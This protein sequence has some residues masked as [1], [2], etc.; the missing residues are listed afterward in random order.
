MQELSRIIRS[1]NAQNSRTINN[2]TPQSIARKI[3]NILHAVR[4]TG[5]KAAHGESISPQDAQKALLDIFSLANLIT[6]KSH[7]IDYAKPNSHINLFD[8]L[9]LNDRHSFTDEQVEFFKKF[10]KFLVDKNQH[11]FILDGYAGTGKTYLISVL[12]EYLNFIE[13]ANVI[14]SPTG[15][16]AQV[17][18]A[19]LA[20]DEAQTIHSVVYQRDKLVE[21]KELNAENSQDKQENIE[22]KFHFSLKENNFPS[23]CVYIFDEASMIS[24]KFSD[25]ES[26]I[27]GS[28]RL[29]KDAFDFIDIG[30]KEHSKKVLFIGDGAQLPPVKMSTSPALDK[31]YLEKN[32]KFNVLKSK[33]TQVV[34][35]DEK[36]GILKASLKLRRGLE[37]GDF[38]SLQFE[39]D[40][41]IRK[42]SYN[43]V[44]EKYA[45]AVQKDGLNQTKMIAYTNDGVGRLNRDIRATLGKNSILEND[46]LLLVARNYRNDNVG[47]IYNGDFVR[48]K[49][50]MLE[51][52][53]EKSLFYK[54]DKEYLRVS[55]CDALIEL[56]NGEEARVKFI[57]SYFENLHNHKE[58]P[59]DTDLELA[60]YIDFK[61]RFESKEFEPIRE[62]MIYEALAKSEAYQR[63]DKQGKRIIEKEIKKEVFVRHLLIDPYY[64]ALRVKFGYAITCHKAQGGEWKNVFIDCSFEQQKQKSALYFRWLYTALTRSTDKVYLLNAPTLSYTLG[65]KIHIH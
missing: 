23:D 18:S 14:A 43:N 49:R 42:I 60:L 33:I 3:I 1:E 2:E 55:F 27:F 35:Q 38:S 47:V 19:R 15:R 26:L 64:T 17:V 45:Q 10:D 32:F 11:I 34:R 58:Q 25:T 52:R 63:A 51:T 59:K 39:F 62:Q 56:S 4:I 7:A 29:L 36:S 5:N 22:I 9:E 41:N 48:L 50:L 24:D 57:Y 31:D 12:N 6:Q 20:G 44:L 16:A 65:K 21:F 46:E 37:S 28:G 13:R 8:F 54:K 30:I 61:K 53:E 40:E